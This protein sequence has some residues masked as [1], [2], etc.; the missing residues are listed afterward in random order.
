MTAFEPINL[1]QVAKLRVKDFL[2]LNDAGAFEQYARTELIE[3]EIWVMNAIY[4]THGKAHF[5][6]AFQLR[7]AL[8]AAG[9]DATI[10]A[11]SS[12]ELSGDSLPEPDI[13]VAA[14]HTG[15]PIPSAKVRLLVEVADTTL[16]N[17]LGRKVKLYARHCIPEYWVADIEGRRIVRMWEPNGADD[18]AK[19]DETPFGSPV[20]SATIAGVIVQTGG[21]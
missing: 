18:Y 13:I 8:D 2:S 19:K 21:I 7:L 12:V 20:G 10:Y 14:D 1:P 3:G 4:S 11:P 5:E 15:G 9:I 6:L 16:A 17:D